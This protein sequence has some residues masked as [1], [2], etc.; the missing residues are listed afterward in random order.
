MNIE[1][2][3]YTNLLPWL[4]TDG[5]EIIL[6]IA[7]VFIVRKF[8]HMAIDKIVRSSVSRD[9]Y[10]T[11]VDERA[12][13]DT[14]IQILE[15]V[16]S[17]LLWIVALMMI[18]SSIGINI[19]PLLAGAGLVGVAVGFGAQYLVRDMITGLFI[20]L[21]NQYR[22]GDI[23]CLDG[24]CGTVE[25][26]TLRTTTLRD[27][28][29]VVHTVPN[30][31]IKKTS[32]MSRDWSRVNLVVGVSYGD[33][34]EK[35]ERVINEVGQD[36]ADDP[37]WSDRI[38]EAPVF[39]RVDNLNDSSVDIRILGKTTPNSQWA[40]TGEL[41]KRLKIT[42]DKEGIEIPFPQKVIHNEK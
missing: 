18:L 1:E 5:L 8:G 17:V 40:V 42:F 27:L 28:D 21:E 35:V 7:G 30:G 9:A 36:L 10:G 33:D 20:I 14:L 13:E 4:K 39:L 24:A 37:A 22:V 6:V 16:V 15:G 3:F 32:N 34:L 26:V 23:I 11:D 31:E 2:I 12:R 25:T 29:G 41:R 38:M 19:A